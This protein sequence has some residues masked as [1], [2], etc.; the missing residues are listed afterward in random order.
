MKQINFFFLIPVFFFSCVSQ[1]LTVSN[2]PIIDETEKNIEFMLISHID[3]YMTGRIPSD[4]IAALFFEVFINRNNL[5]GN[6]QR[7][8]AV[9]LMND[10][11]SEE[12]WHSDGFDA[13][14]GEMNK[15]ALYMTCAMLS[16]QDDSF[17]ESAK[18]LSYG[19]GWYDYPMHYTVV[20]FLELLINNEQIEKTL[21]DLHQYLSDI[22][23]SGNYDN[24]SEIIKNMEYIQSILS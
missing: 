18:A 10:V 12:G 11:L 16:P 13:R 23:D 7:E 21:T 19:N 1:Q 20:V 24:G 9:A 4:E 17:I 5:N 15:I 22:I 8:R 3:E 14:K 2:V 6:A